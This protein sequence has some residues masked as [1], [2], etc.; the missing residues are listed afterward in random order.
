MGDI[1]PAVVVAK[2]VKGE[3]IDGFDRDHVH[4]VE[5]CA[6]WCAPCQETIPRLAGLAK[7]FSGKEKFLAVSVAEKD[8]AAVKPFVAKM[9]KQ[10]KYTVAI[11][12]VSSEAKAA[13]GI[14]IKGWLEAAGLSGI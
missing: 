1:A 5:F 2:T 11:H 9:G 7:K 12:G 13:D 4:V 6:T 10:M 14:I 3:S 8:S